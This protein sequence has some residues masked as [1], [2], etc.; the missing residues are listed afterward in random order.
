MDQAKIKSC[1]DLKGMGGFV[2]AGD[3]D[4][5][6][7]AEFVVT[8]GTRHLAAFDHTGALMWSRTRRG[9]GQVRVHVECEMP[10]LVYDIDGDGRAEV[11]AR[12]YLQD[13][14]DAV[15]FI[16]ILDG[17]TGEIRRQTALPIHLW[18]ES[19]VSADNGVPH[20]GSLVVGRIE[21]D[22]PPHLIVAGMSWGLAI[23]D[24]ELRLRFCDPQ[25]GR[26][27]DR[28]T[29][30]GLC[31]TPCLFDADGDGVNEL[32]LGRTTCRADGTV[33]WTIDPEQ[34]S[35]AQIDHVDSLAVADLD[36]DGR[37]E[38]AASNAGSVFDARTGALLW[39]HRDRVDHGQQLRLGKVRD[40]VPGLQIVVL[41]TSRATGAQA[42]IFSAR[43]DLLTTV[44]RAG[45]LRVLRWLGND[46]QQV[47]LGRT[48]YDGDG[49]PL[50]TLPLDDAARQAGH[51]W[52]AADR[53]TWGHTMACDVDADG[54]EELI[55]VCRTH[56]VVFGHSC[57]PPSPAR[58]VRDD[59]YWLRIANTTRY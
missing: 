11:I 6:G 43:G 13:T 56:L 27:H 34:F 14:R 12:W 8:Q 33:L 40:D 4:G 58:L 48:V 28:M 1:I 55:W 30:F 39:Q 50:A 25:F 41:S 53:S 47:A 10:T 20:S 45:L 37:Y 15:P 17:Q 19:T 22:G 29:G 59:A 2:S 46:L 26:V 3:L 57:P 31:H 51:P 23:F 54:L 18:P 44:P 24:S 7:Q 35:P 36:D 52:P 32:F 21:L 42:L 49:E 16:Q 38:M 9:Y 5:D